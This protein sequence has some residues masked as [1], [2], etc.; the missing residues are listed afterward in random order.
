MKRQGGIS[1]EIELQNVGEAWDVNWVREMQTASYGFENMAQGA[2]KVRPGAQQTSQ[3]R[4][5]QRQGS[6]RESIPRLG[7]L[8][9]HG[10]L[11]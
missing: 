8:G 7:V 5:R 10:V 9:I 11:Y 4:F 3:V 2:L 6:W 1:D